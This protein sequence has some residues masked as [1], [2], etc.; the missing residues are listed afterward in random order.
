LLLPQQ[1]NPG[2]SARKRVCVSISLSYI[3]FSHCV[4]VCSAGI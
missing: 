3:F 2:Q 4:Y 1:Q